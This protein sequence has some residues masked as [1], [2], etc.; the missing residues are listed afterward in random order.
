MQ[1][2]YSLCRIRQLGLMLVQ[3]CDVVVVVPHLLLIAQAVIPVT[4]V[5]ISDKET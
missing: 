3:G 2:S 1:T 4:Q 5:L